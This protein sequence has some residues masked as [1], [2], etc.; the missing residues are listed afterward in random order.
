MFSHPSS[1][2][3]K[4]LLIV[5][6]FQ[7]SGA[8]GGMVVGSVFMYWVSL[9]IG[10]QAA[11]VSYEREL[12]SDYPLTFQIIYDLGSFHRDQHKLKDAERMYQR[13]L[14]GYEAALVED[15]TSCEGVEIFKTNPNV[16][17]YELFQIE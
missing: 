13:I 4:T 6:T 8:L 5:F 15:P 14:A 2:V 17:C 16:Y 1:G 12:G 9:I 11:L 3:R 7:N 10:R